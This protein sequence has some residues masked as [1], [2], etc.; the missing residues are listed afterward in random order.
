MLGV[1]IKNP[2]PRWLRLEPTQYGVRVVVLC[3]VRRYERGRLVSA[4]VEAADGLSHAAICVSITQVDRVVRI[5]LVVAFDRVLDLAVLRIG[6]YVGI[7]ETDGVG[8]RTACQRKEIIKQRRAGD[9]E[10]FDSERVREPE[11]VGCQPRQTEIAEPVWP[12]RVA[13]QN[14]LAQVENVWCRCR[15]ARRK[16]GDARIPIATGEVLNEIVV[17][18]GLAVDD[19]T[20]NV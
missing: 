14:V 10:C 7:A 11:L 1:K 9:L 20:G 17:L 18:P 4:E 6:Q 3:K 13:S 5:K 16:A 12:F 19:A 2:I 8:P 15:R